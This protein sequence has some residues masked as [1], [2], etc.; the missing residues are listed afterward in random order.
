MSKRERKRKGKKPPIVPIEI[1]TSALPDGIPF[2]PG[3]RAYHLGECKVLVGRNEKAGWHISIAHSDRF[4]TWDEVRF[5][6][7][8]L[9]PPGMTLLM[10]V[11]PEE[12]LQLNVFHLF[13]FSKRE[14]MVEVKDPRGKILGVERRE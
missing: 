3:A 12:Q 11:A 4:P 5:A 13:E 7:T 9:L 6:R 10:Y 2:E 8:K 14:S 1:P